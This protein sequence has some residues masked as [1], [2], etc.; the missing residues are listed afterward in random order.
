MLTPRNDTETMIYEVLKSIKSNYTLIDVWTW[1]WRIIIAILK[2]INFN[3]FW[4]FWTDISKDAL[5]VAKININYHNLQEKVCLLQQDLLEFFLNRDFNISENVILT[6]NLPYIK[7][8]DI[9]N[10]D[11]EVL[12]NDP[13]IALFW[14]PKTWFETYERL[15]E[16]VFEFKKKYSVK[17]LTLFIE[18]WFDQYNYSKKYLSNLSLKFEYFKD[19]NNI[20]RIIK[21]SF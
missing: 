15:I 16:Q 10:I 17:S 9:D 3:L 19:L 7:D 5:D 4:V 2:N 11:K 1:S 6:A 18:I 20:N 21:I 8:W 13:H 12:K 14:W